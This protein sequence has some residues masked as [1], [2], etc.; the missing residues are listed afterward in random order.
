MKTIRYSTL[1]AARI[2]GIALR[3]P[4][5]GIEPSRGAIYHQFSQGG[6]HRFLY[7]PQL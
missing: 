5:S 1:A 4:E 3:N 6:R 2:A 7:V